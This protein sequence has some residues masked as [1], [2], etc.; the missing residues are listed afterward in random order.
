[1]YVCILS[2]S[3]INGFCEHI[4]K[5]PRFQLKNFIGL[6]PEKLSLKNAYLNSSIMILILPG[7]KTLHF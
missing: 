2:H 6:C 4:T 1:M 7:G 5:L 3:L